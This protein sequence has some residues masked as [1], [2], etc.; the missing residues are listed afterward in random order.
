MSGPPH[1][2][3]PGTDSHLTSLRK[4]RPGSSMFVLSK[5]RG[6]GRRK[7]E[8]ATRSDFCAIFI[9]HTEP[10]FVLAQY[11][12]KRDQTHFTWAFDG[13]RSLSASNESKV[14]LDSGRS[15]QGVQGLSPFDRFVFVMSILSAT[16]VVSV[17]LF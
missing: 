5:K 11:H 3:S 15:L 16:L 10:L 17:P 2:E 12:Q 13:I 1:T 9:E 7:S 6:E 4:L 8:Y 14:N